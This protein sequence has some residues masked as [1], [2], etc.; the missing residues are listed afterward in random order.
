MVD[1]TEEFVG[2]DAERLS[3]ALLDVGGRKPAA[4][5]PA[6]VRLIDAGLLGE[7][8]LGHFKAPAGGPESLVHDVRIFRI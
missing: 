3:E 8:L 1:V 7:L 2:R 5:D 6:D 4:L